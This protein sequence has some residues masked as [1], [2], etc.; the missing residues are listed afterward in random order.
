MART[1][2]IF[3]QAVNGNF[4]GTTKK[5]LFEEINASY[6]RVC[7][8]YTIDQI[9]LYVKKGESGGV[10]PTVAVNAVAFDALVVELV[11]ELTLSTNDGTTLLIN[12]VNFTFGPK[13]HLQ[14]I[15][16]NVNAAAPNPPALVWAKVYTR[17]LD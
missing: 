12:C 11:P 4:D 14:I 7:G 10:R 6:G 2:Q 16:Q 13:D 9:V 1:F 17:G 5:G 8:G 15:T 3:T